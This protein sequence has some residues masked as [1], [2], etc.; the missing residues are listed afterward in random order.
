M[1]GIQ[2]S[3]NRGMD[4]LASGGCRNLRQYYRER[5]HR[6]R[7]RTRETSDRVDARVLFGISRAQSVPRAQRQPEPCGGSL[8]QW[9]RTTTLIWHGELNAFAPTKPCKRKRKH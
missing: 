9:S 7:G 4:I 1:A 2:R 5:L 8:S 6:R 3:D